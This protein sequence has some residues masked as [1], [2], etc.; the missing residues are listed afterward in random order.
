MQ[1]TDPQ[2]LQLL[3]ALEASE[4]ELLEKRFQARSRNEKVEK[5]W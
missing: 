3:K 1:R 2:L 5:D 4:K